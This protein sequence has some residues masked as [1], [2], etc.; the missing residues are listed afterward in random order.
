MFENFIMA[1]I[2]IGA[3][4]WGGK[5]FYQWAHTRGFNEG[6]KYHLT[7]EKYQFDG[8]KDRVKALETS[9]K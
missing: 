8:L 5:S 2:I 3:T 4:V 7:V 1:S 9:K 6:E